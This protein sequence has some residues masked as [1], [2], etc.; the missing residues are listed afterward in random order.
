MKLK[1][2]I[3]LMDIV[4]I[5]VAVGLAGFSVYTV[6]I[7]KTEGRP[8][9]IAYNQHSQWIYPLD[10]N[11]TFGVPGALWEDTVIRIEDGQAWVEYSPCDNQLCVGM[12]KVSRNGAMVSCLPNM[13]FFVIQ[14]RNE[15]SDDPDRTTW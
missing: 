14:G 12:G 15:Q 5:L 7:K 3:K 4:I 10:T 6:Y 8:M 11:E 2:P 13:V 1:L 9:V